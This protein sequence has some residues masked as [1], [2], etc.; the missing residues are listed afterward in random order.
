MIVR[1]IASKVNACRLSMVDPFQSRSRVAIRFLCKKG[2][3]EH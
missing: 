1:K 3:F 2:P